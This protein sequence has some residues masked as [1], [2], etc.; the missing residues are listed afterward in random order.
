[1]LVSVDALVVLVD[2]IG[3]EVIVGLELPLRCVLFEEYAFVTYEL[4]VIV[5]KL[6]IAT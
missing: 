1:M 6:V 4:T 3:E 5:V 2:R